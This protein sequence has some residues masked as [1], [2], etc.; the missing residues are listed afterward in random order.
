MNNF[1]NIKNF[2]FDCDGVLYQ[3]LESVFGQV[4][5]KM[6]EYISKNLNLDLEKA[7]ELQTNYFHKYNTSLNGLMIHHN[8]NPEEFLK[9]VHEINLDF[10]KKDLVLREELIKLDCKKFIFTNGSHEHVKN[11]TKHLGIDDLFDGVFDITD[12]KLIPKPSLE[13]YKK[14]VKKFD[15]IPEETIF[16]EDIAKNLEPAKKLGMK[17]I[18]LINDEYWGK[19]DSDKDFIDLKIKNLSSFL[20]EIN[21][22][23]VA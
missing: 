9:Y 17:T 10:M 5:K 2:I 16:I 4:S 8:V 11:I 21:I 20:K 15:I 23:K 3:D 22:L 14:L 18:W 7:K 13:P 1:K 12:C 19:K 6:T